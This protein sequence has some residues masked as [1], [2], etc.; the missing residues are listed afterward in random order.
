MQVYYGD[1]N[2]LAPDGEN[3]AKTMRLRV[4]PC[5]ALLLP[6][7]LVLAVKTMRRRVLPC[8]AL[9]LPLGLVLAVG[10]L[11][12]LLVSIR[13]WVW[14][15][16]KVWVWVWMRVREEEDEVG[17]RSLCLCVFLCRHRCL[18]CSQSLPLLVSRAPMPIAGAAH[19]HR[20]R[21]R[22]RHPPG[23]CRH[24]PEHE[25][26]GRGQ[27]R[28]GRGQSLLHAALSHHVKNKGTLP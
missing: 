27:P 12:P 15:W 21:H 3:N 10:T 22:H 28:P 2:G 11:M 23:T 8:L 14:V 6:L 26:L 20:H 4:L 19:R 18:H 24:G 16:M 9:L 13:V 5:L 17:W 25:Q 1:T 7:G